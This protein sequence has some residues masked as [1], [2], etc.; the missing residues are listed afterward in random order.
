M[1]TFSEEEADKFELKYYDSEVHRAA[2]VLPRFMRKVSS[3]YYSMND[4]QDRRRQVS[5]LNLYVK[6][7]YL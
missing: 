3:F 5:N 7:Q 2:F 4:L 6:L 1:T